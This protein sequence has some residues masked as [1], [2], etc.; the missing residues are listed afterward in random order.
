L[1]EQ[2][3]KLVELRLHGV[4]ARKSG[5][6]PDLAD[7]RI[8]GAINVL[9]R[10]EIAQTGV[11]LGRDAFEQRCSQSRLANTGLTGEQLY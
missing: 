10:A 6:A 9:W 3:V 4:I 7:G 5:G 1:C 2:R 8:K 11:R